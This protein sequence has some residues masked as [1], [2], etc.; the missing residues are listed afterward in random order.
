MY[1]T[2][3]SSSNIE[4]LPKWESKAPYPKTSVLAACFKMG[5]FPWTKL[6]IVSGCWG[7]D[8]WPLYLSPSW[9]KGF[10]YTLLLT[11]TSLEKCWASFQNYLKEYCYRKIPV[12]RLDYLRSPSSHTQSRKENPKQESRQKQSFHWLFSNK[13]SKPFNK[14][15]THGVVWQILGD[16]SDVSVGKYGSN[17]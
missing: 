9:K 12:L 14:P 2:N 10:T 5:W 1:R 16:S 3:I 17:Y 4:H 15:F 13:L 11:A 6:E 8:N 7:K